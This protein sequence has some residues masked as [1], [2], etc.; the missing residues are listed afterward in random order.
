MIYIIPVVV[1][2]K[3]CFQWEKLSSVFEEFVS[4]ESFFHLKKNKTSDVDIPN[5]YRNVLRAEFEF[6]RIRYNLNF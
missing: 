2:N 1:V 5:F 6:F 4:R 3:I